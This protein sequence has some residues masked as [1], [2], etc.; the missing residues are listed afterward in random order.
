MATVAQNAV[1]I[2]IDGWGIREDPYGNAI[3][4]AKTPCMDALKKDANWAEVDASGLAVGLPEGLMGNS[5]VGHLTIGAGQVQYQDLVRINLAV[6]DGSLK[7]NKALTEAFANAKAKSGRLHFL[8]LLSDGGVHS[9]I[10][11]LFA[12]LEYAK[13]AGV[14][15]TFVQAF[16]D[17]RDTPP[18]SGVKYIQQLL[19]H[20]SSI[21]YGS[22]ASMCGRYYA[23]DRDKRWERVQVSYESLVAGKGEELK[24]GES[25]IDFMK[26]K[27]AEKELDEFLKP[28]ICD[29]DGLIQ[30]GD[31]LVYFDFRSDRMREP[32][33][34]MAVKR[35]FETTVE[36][37]KDL[38][39][40]QFTQYSARS[41]P[42]PTRNC[43]EDD[44]S[45][46]L[47]IIFPPQEM[48]NGIS[49]W[50]S[51]KKRV[52]LVQESSPSC[53]VSVAAAD[54]IR[55]FHTAETEKYAHV[56][57]FFNGGRELQFELEER[58]MV[59][60][61]KV[62]T[63]DLE[64]KM[65]ANGVKDSLIEAMRTGNY[66][67]L[68]CNFAPPDMVGHTGKFDPAVIAV[69]ETD[70]CI[71]EIHAACKELGYALLITADHGNAEVM[72][73]EA[74]EPVTS[75]TTSPVPFVLYDP[76][77]KAKFTRTKGE[78]ADV[79]PT[80]LK[81]MGI[82]IPAEMTGKSMI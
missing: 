27:Y 25:P 65:N 63:Y 21:K 53:A 23:M 59:P 69:E 60:S 51:K 1:L 17:G 3:H 72:K 46:P 71:G 5:E 42:G 54:R 13:D 19:D 31:T 47:P 11:H 73:T 20:M 40:V 50:L 57:F 37:P 58:A 28:V 77:G 24:A 49:E 79:A 78:V 56:T 32:V 18:D 15:K 8:G 16:T 67:F 2:V 30:S 55:Q 4:A 14:P 34:T 68:M 45:F 64:P 33:E 12:L 10:D 41:F 44:S 74:G 76:R 29:K 52:S 80:L 36:H 7:R 61:P 38:H 75:H 26:K 43:S 82:E 66:P 35:N 22:L 81:L 62:A 48:T 39:V 6:K 70:R 9:H